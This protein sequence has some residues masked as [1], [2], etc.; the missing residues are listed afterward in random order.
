MPIEW[1]QSETLKYLVCQAL[2][3]VVTLGTITT[4]LSYVWHMKDSPAMVLDFGY[5]TKFK[6]L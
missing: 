3:V 5:S 6:D 4:T 2:L 1:V